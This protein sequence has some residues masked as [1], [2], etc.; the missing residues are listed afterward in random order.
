MPK[1][2]LEVPFLLMR[3]PTIQ[4]ISLWLQMLTSGIYSFGSIRNVGL[5]F[6]KPLLLFN[7]IRE[8]DLI[9]RGSQVCLQFSHPEISPVIYV[10]ATYPTKLFTMLDPQNL[11]ID[12]L[13]AA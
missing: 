9:W 4:S 7:V 3:A 10:G 13:Y 2:Y 8:L 12:E 11:E 1:N 5:Y 6:T